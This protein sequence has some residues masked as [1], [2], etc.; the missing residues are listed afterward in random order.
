MMRNKIFKAMMMIGLVAAIATT[1][2]AGSALTPIYAAEMEAAQGNQVVNGV[3]DFGKGSASININGNEGQ[4]LVG[5]KFEI[6]QLFNAENS[7]D[8]ES[9]NYTLQPELANALQSD[10][11]N[12]LNKKT[13]TQLRPSDVTEYLP[14]VYIQTL[15]T[16]KV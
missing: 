8:G 14:I 6:F 16:N 7:K 15:I 1:S 12:P 4:S 11:A 13:G 3:L 9:I 2:M 10:L 5:K